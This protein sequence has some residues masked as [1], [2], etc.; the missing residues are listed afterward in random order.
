MCANIGFAS[1]AGCRAGCRTRRVMRVWVKVRR[2]RENP[3]HSPRQFLFG[4][5]HYNF[6]PA[7]EGKMQMRGLMKIVWV[8]AFSLGFSCFHC[9]LYGA[10]VQFG[11]KSQELK[12]GDAMMHTSLISL[13]VDFG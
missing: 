8:V 9:S 4:K 2:S 3:A 10:L 11:C 12:H 5:F 13:F 7:V 6:S 1:M